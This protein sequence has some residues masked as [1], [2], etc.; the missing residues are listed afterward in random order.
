MFCPERKTF[1]NF[2]NIEEP[3]TKPTVPPPMAYCESEENWDDTDVPSYNPQEYIA[4]APVLRNIQGAP[5]SERKQF[6][7]QERLRLL[8]VDN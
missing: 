3:V 2:R 1:E 6:R 8:G 5:P 7:K 4:K